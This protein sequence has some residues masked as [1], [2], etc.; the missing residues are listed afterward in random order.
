[1]LEK[2]I[3]YSPFTQCPHTAMLRPDSRKTQFDREGTRVVV[4]EDGF[5]SP[6]GTKQGIVLSTRTLSCCV[7]R[8]GMPNRYYSHVLESKLA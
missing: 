3:V 7:S 2:I 4:G 6:L 1:M 8:P 5:G